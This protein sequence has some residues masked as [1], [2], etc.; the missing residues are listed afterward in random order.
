MQGA[1]GI[2]A[3]NAQRAFHVSDLMRIQPRASPPSSPAMAMFTSTTRERCASTMER[4]GR[5]WE[6][7]PLP[8]V[9]GNLTKT[10]RPQDLDRS[11]SPV[12][13][14]VLGSSPSEG[15]TVIPRHAMTSAFP[16]LLVFALLS[17][18]ASAHVSV[19]DRDFILSQSEIACEDGVT[20]I[21]LNTTEREAWQLDADKAEGWKIDVTKQEPKQHCEHCFEV[22]GIFL[23]YTPQAP[24]PLPFN[25]WLDMRRDAST[26]ALILDYRFGAGAPQ[27]ERLG[28]LCRLL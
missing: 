26:E 13:E 22:E 1:V 10:W 21:G 20:L 27:G 4:V 23:I 6:P 3:T 12:Y 17:P 19:I 15:D 5:G 16:T 28:L 24:F 11:Q 8:E 25:V 9:R 7:E 2:G 14:K 18:S